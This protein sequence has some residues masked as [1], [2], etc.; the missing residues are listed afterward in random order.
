MLARVFIGMEGIYAQLDA[1]QVMGSI[2]DVSCLNGDGPTA[3]G[4]IPPP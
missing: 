2:G 4:V 1:A 3:K